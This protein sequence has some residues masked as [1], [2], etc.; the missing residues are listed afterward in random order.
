[1]PRVLVVDDQLGMREL[2][3][4]M[5]RRLHFETVTAPN[6]ASALAYLQEDNDFQVFFVD[7]YLPFMN[8]A[9]FVREVKTRYPTIPT[10]VMTAHLSSDLIQ[11]AMKLGADVQ[12]EYPYLPQNVVKALQ[13]VG[14]LPE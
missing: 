11:V 8:G 12:L 7:M 13:A 6:A 5:L 1:V 10:I 9:E 4:L 14:V 3:V 2:M